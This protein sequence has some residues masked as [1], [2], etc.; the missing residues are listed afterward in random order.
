MDERTYRRLVCVGCGLP[1]HM[2]RDRC[3]RSISCEV[4]FRRYL[5]KP[6]IVAAPKEP[7]I[8]RKREKIRPRKKAK[9]GRG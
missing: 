2:H 6:T 1:V 3:G 9:H 4:L 8:P 5:P 7:V